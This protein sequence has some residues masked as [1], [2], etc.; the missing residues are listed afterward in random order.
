MRR[1]LIFSSEFFKI[2]SNKCLKKKIKEFRISIRELTE[3]TF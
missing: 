2:K 3:D 1:S